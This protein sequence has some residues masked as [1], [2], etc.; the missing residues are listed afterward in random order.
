MSKDADNTGSAA[1][2]L[3]PLCGSNRFTWGVA[4]GYG[5]LVFKPDDSGWVKTFFDVGTRIKAR[6]CDSCGN[7]QL[8]ALESVAFEQRPS[9]ETP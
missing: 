8:F 3:C 9:F 6:R 4:K 5:P 2:N 7:I 1:R